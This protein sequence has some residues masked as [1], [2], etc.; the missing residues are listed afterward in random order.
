MFI[1]V[2]LLDFQPTTGALKV[3][4]HIKNYNKH[5]EPSPETADPINL[6]GFK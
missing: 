3:L 2:A 4:H 5:D 1:P 6:Q